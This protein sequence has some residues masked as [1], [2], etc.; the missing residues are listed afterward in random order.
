MRITRKFTGS[1]AMRLYTGRALGA[2]ASL[3]LVTA[4]LMPTAVSAEEGDGPYVIMIGAPGSGKSTA[5]AYIS[6]ST[7][8]PVI[9]VGEMLRDLVSGAQA[10]SRVWLRVP[11]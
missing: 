3:L 9:E 11:V 5:S 1:A 4:A 7:G 2:L 10:G 6:D 8:V